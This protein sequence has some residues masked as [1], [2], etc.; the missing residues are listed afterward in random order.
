[1]KYKLR[2]NSYGM[3]DDF[4]YKNIKNRINSKSQEDLVQS[5]RNIISMLL[6]RLEYN[7]IIDRDE[8]EEILGEIL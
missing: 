4:N 2:T 5:L 8:V 7:K 1:M 3:I 6:V